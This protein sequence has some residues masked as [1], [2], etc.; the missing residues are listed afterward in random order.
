MRRAS[1]ELQQYMYRTG[2]CG[3][4]GGDGGKRGP[5]WALGDG[6]GLDVNGREP[7]L[8]LAALGRWD[9]R[10]LRVAGADEAAVAAAVRAVVRL[11]PVPAVL[12]SDAGVFHASSRATGR[13]RRRRRGSSKLLLLLP[14]V[15]APPF[16]GS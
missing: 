1:W 9:V 13:R 11:G 15:E 16:G 10:G 3:G 4:V 2:R 12:A 14:C 8:A 5:V 7:L 6:H